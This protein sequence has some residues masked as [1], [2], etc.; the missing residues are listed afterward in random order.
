MVPLFLLFAAQAAAVPATAAL[1]PAAPAAVIRDP[2]TCRNIKLTGSRLNS[3]RVCMLRSRW[4][5]QTS[6]DQKALRDMQDKLVC[7]RNGC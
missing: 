6:E 4:D 7:V 1:P 2:M 5:D 3:R